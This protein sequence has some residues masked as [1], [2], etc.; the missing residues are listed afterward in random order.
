MLIIRRRAGE[1]IVIDGQIEVE[2]LEASGSQVKLGIR[3]PRTIP[4][5][6]KEIVLVQE[7]N[8]EASRAIPSDTLE[9][10]ASALRKPHSSPLLPVR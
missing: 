5:L 8:Q 1:S 6:R 3:A 7:Q 4:V 2:V 9:R 10:V